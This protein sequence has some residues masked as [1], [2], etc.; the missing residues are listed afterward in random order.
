MTYHIDGEFTQRSE[1]P[2]LHSE[3]QHHEF[4]QDVS[5][6][7]ILPDT[8]FICICEEAVLAI[9]QLKTSRQTV[10]DFITL[11]LFWLSHISQKQRRTDLTP[12]SLFSNEVTL[13]NTWLP[14]LLGALVTLFHCVE[15]CMFH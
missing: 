1:N 6:Y 4:Y 7:E 11:Y 2:S 13:N 5:F 8:A 10:S 12:A 3:E 9:Q 15:P 14:G